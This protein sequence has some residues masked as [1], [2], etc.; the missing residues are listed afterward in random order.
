MSA[1][2]KDPIMSFPD[3]IE[4]IRQLDIPENKWQTI[5]FDVFRK[6]DTYWLDGLVKKEHETHRPEAQP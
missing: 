4:W 6:G 1:D 3:L 5:A 2:T